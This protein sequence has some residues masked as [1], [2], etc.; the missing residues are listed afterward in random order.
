MLDTPFELIE[1]LEYVHRQAKPTQQN[2]PAKSTTATQSKIQ[3]ATVQ[4]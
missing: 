4:Q 1:S 3:Q 2:V